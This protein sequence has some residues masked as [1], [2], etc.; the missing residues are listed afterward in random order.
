M[1]SNSK[2][3]SLAKF[4]ACLAELAAKSYFFQFKAI[5]ARNAY[6]ATRPMRAL[7]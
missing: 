7:P 3:A 5:R 4:K 1:D 2:P 6:A